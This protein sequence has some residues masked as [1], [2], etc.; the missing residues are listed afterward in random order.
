METQELVQYALAPVDPSERRAA[1]SRSEPH[2]HATR[3]ELQVAERA[4]TQLVELQGR[5]SARLKTVVKEIVRVRPAI[6]KSVLKALDDP[7]IHRRPDVSAALAEAASKRHALED[8]RLLLTD[9]LE[10]L[11]AEELPIANMRRLES[12]IEFNRA[13][14][15]WVLATAIVDLADLLE[16]LKAL[17]EADRGI[18]V[19]ITPDSKASVYAAK[20]NALDL[21]LDDRSLSTYTF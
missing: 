7:T 19:S 18:A 17:T 4:V 11:A 2:V 5:G 3:A 6:A 9:A 8:Q 10:F 12:A 20:I 21:E 13:S 1:V 15:D 14:R 16:K